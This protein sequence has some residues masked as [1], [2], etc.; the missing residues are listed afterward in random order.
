MAEDAAPASSSSP[1]T[2]PGGCHSTATASSR[3][4]AETQRERRRFSASPRL[5]VRPVVL[6]VHPPPGIDSYPPAVAG[7]FSATG[8]TDDRV[9]RAAEDGPVVAWSGGGY[10]GRRGDAGSFLPALRRFVPPSREPPLGCAR[11]A[12]T[13]RRGP[14]AGP[15]DG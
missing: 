10:I 13:I 14:R 11:R 9:R 7:R 1:A 12:R 4:A 6:G 2:G 8:G 3:R 5:C 15:T